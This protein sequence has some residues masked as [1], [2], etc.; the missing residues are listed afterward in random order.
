M[1]RKKKPE[2]DPEP[3]PG[4]SQALQVTKR[5]DEI[6]VWP[7]D[8]DGN[9]L[10]E[11]PRQAR[12]R[13]MLKRMRVFRDAYERC[14]GNLSAASRITGIAREHHY[15]WMNGNLPHHRYYQRIMRETRPVDVL[16][17]AAE[18]TVFNEINNGNLTA[19]MFT[20]N[21]LG[22]RRGWLEA[23]RRDDQ[24]RPQLSESATQKAISAYRLW[25]AENPAADQDEK[26]E[27]LELFATRLG[28]PESEVRREMALQEYTEKAGS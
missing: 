13:S 12:L 9:E 19:A 21:K 18:N 4:H 7:L 24:A 3:Q 22:H 15:I 11:S 5:H 14:G 27:W 6:T 8:D 2:P 25:L 20:I 28:V 26:E 16:L 1:G 17:D 10:N 23:H